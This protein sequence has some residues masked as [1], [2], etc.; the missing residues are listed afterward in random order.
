MKFLK[1]ILLSISLILLATP[2]TTFASSFPDVNQ[3]NPYYTAINYLHDQNILNGYSDGYYRP[4]NPVSRIELLKIVMN[5]KG[6][7]TSYD[8]NF[9]FPDI[10][11]NMWYA[12]YVSTAFKS[13]HINGNNGYFFPNNTVTKAESLKIIFNIVGIEKATN[14]E[15]HVFQDVNKNSWYAPYFK[16]A[17]DLNLIDGSD[18]DKIGAHDP[19]DRGEIAEIMYRVLTSGDYNSPNPDGETFTGEGTYT[20]SIGDKLYD[21]LNDRYIHFT[22]SNVL[23]GVNQITY[24]TL[25]GNGNMLKNSSTRNCDG[26]T[27]GGDYEHSSL[28]LDNTL[29]NH[30]VDGGFRINCNKNTDNTY[31]M[32][33]EYAL[34]YVFE[35]AMGT[36]KILF[37]PIYLS[38]QVD[39]VDDHDLRIEH[40]IEPAL[41]E[42]QAYIKTKQLQYLG[43]E[44]MW[45]DFT[46][47]DYIIPPEPDEYYFSPTGTGVDGYI[48]RLDLI[49]DETSLNP[50]DFDI[51]FY[52]MYTTNNSLSDYGVHAGYHLTNIMF[53]PGA[54]T[55]FDLN[56][57]GI[58][59]GQ[60]DVVTDGGLH[61]ILHNLGMTD[62]GQNQG[63][64]E[65]YIGEMYDGSQSLSDEY[66][67]QVDI[68]GVEMVG[69]FQYIDD[70]TAHEIGWTDRND[71]GIGDTDEYKTYCDDRYEDEGYEFCDS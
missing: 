14:I 49:E 55:A 42:I 50:D 39:E 58:M 17:K 26:K 41:E 57:P 19:M 70:F 37:V 7:S 23:S 61:E 63:K 69:E 38:D 28:P 18:E 45:F 64:H 9:T 32:E 20:V 47:S 68:Y 35:K 59:H 53:S 62:L 21:E 24:I 22:G 40:I 31:D 51:I 6:V 34:Q 4:Y 54:V 43:E 36:K 15:D 52:R 44:I 11:T 3:S 12:K 8:L 30:L 71:N 46:I 25:D 66:C 2:I 29:M 13:G 27:F 65:C 10:D 60:R 33:Y 16:T 67:T 56:H 1:H 5:T 48:N